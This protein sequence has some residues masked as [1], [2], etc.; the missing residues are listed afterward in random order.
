MT[1]SG[2]LTKT[3]FEI[4]FLEKT[5]SEANNFDHW[6]KKSARHKRQKKKV[7]VAINPFRKHLFFPCILRL[8]RYAPRFLDAHDNLRMSLKYIVDQVCAEITQDFRAGR[9]DDKEGFTFE[10]AQ[11][12]SK[13]YKVKIE[14]MAA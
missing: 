14:F 9:A 4:E 8:T 6:T 5:V 10:Y 7:S 3:G 2:K 11:E 1:F 13:E 12:K